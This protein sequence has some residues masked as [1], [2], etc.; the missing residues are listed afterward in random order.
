MGE[1]SNEEDGYR[2]GNEAVGSGG[3]TRDAGAGG[4]VVRRCGTEEVK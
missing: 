2:S 4:A 1:E 3:D